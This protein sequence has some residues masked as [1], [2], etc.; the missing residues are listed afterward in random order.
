MTKLKTCSAAASLGHGF[1]DSIVDP[2]A[3]LNRFHEEFQ[4]FESLARGSK[5][6]LAMDWD[7][8]KP[9]MEDRTENVRLI[10][11]TSITPPGPPRAG[12]FSAAAACGHLSALYFAAIASAF[13]PVDFYE[14]RPVN[15]RIDGLRTSTPI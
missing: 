8:R 3:G 14:Y 12:D 7:E 2:P 1:P 6:R 10:G 15:L 5:R 4:A 9:C 11:T 13:V